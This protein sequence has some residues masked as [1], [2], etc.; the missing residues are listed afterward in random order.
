MALEEYMG[1]HMLANSAK[2]VSEPGDKNESPSLRHHAN[3]RTER[4]VF[5]I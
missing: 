1:F 5:S 2:Q 4:W 3:V